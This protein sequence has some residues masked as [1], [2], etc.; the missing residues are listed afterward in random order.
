MFSRQLLQAGRRGKG[1]AVETTNGCAIEADWRSGAGSAFLL[2]QFQ[3]LTEDTA[4]FAG[5]FKEVGIV[6]GLQPGNAG[7]QQ[8]QGDI[9]LV[10]LIARAASHASSV[11]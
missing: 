7:A 1:R 3:G 4:L 10:T 11:P 5:E 9:E 2:R 6:P 8:A